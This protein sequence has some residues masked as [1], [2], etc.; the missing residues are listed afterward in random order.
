MTLPELKPWAAVWSPEMVTK[1]LMGALRW[2]ERSAGHVGPAGMRAVMPPFFLTPNEREWAGW[3]RHLE[4]E[5]PPRPKRALTSRQVSLYEK[6]LWWPTTYLR[7][8]PGPGNVLRVWL[9]CK[10]YRIPFGSECKRRG[11][12]R[13]TAYRARDRALAEIAAGLMRDGIYPGDDE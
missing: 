8:L 5:A 12:S 9:L 11:W 3:D 2:C 7:D 1:A 6:A 4:E 13:A 10:L